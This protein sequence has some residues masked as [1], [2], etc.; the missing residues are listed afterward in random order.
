MEEEKNEAVV[1]DEKPE[2][3]EPEEAE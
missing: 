2:E 1:E 3:V